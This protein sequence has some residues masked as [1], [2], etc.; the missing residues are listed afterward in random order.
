MVQCNTDPGC[1]SYPPETAN[2]LHRDIFWFLLKD[3]EFVSKTTNDSNIDLDKFLTSKV[4]QLAKMME[5]SKAT[6]RHIKQVASDPQTAQSNLMRHQHKDISASKHKMSFVKP[7]PPSDKNDASDRQNNYKKSFDAKNVY[8]NKE[9]YQKCW[10]S[11]HIEGFQCSAKKFQ[12]K[13]CHRY[14]HLPSLCYQKKQAS[15]K[16]RKQKAHMLQEGAVYTCDKSI[17]SH[18]EGSSSDESFHL[19]VKI[20][21]SQAV[22]KKIP[23]PSH[24][25]TN[26]AYKLKPLQTRNQYLRA[27]LGTCAD[28]NIMPASVYKLVFNDWELKKLAPSTFEIGTYKTDTVRIVGSCLFCLVHPDTKKLQEVTFYVAQNDGSVLL[29]CTMTLTLGLI[30]PCTR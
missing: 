3:E 19:Q 27:R 15:F 28:V 17:C 26:L 7:R 8:K 6:V 9:R 30:Q 16:P 22:C 1:L 13:S 18:S 24:L 25:I 10:D 21:Q 5:S 29:S 20:Q 23:T 11:N 4:R 2:I 12:C 14:G